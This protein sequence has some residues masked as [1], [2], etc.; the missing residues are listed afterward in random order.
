MRKNSDDKRL[1]FLRFFMDSNGLTYDDV[2]DMIGMTKSGVCTM[3]SNEVD[4]ARL[5]MVFALARKCGYKLDIIVTKADDKNNRPMKVN[6]DNYIHLAKG[7]VPDDLAFLSL[8]LAK[9]KITKTE[10]AKRLD[11]HVKSV[12]KFFHNQD[13]SVSR[14]LQIASVCNFDIRFEYTQLDAEAEQEQELPRKPGTV[15]VTTTF[16]YKRTKLI[17]IG[18]IRKVVKRKKIEAKPENS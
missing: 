12:N 10:L 7:Y 3:F 5:S 2:G 9:Y 14:L 16:D 11:I 8:A 17:P 4:D 6:V 1:D 15:R 18:N 13:M